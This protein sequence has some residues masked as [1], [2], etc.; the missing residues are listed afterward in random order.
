VNL[1]YGRGSTMLWELRQA[2]GEERLHALLRQYVKEHQYD[3][4]TGERFVS[5]LS[6]EAGTDAA[7]FIDYWLH[8]KLEKQEEAAAWVEKSKHE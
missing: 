5:M 6:R 8:L 1:V 3:Q 4:A 2:W 7:P